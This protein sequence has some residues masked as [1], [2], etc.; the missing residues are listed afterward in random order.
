MNCGKFCSR[1]G[2][3]VGIARVVGRDA[4]AAQIDAQ[5][6]IV[7]DRVALDAIAGAAGVGRL[8]RRSRVEGNRSCPA[9]AAVPPIDCCCGAALDLDAFCCRWE[10]PSDPAKSLPMKLP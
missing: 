7:A 10:W 4:I 8:R 2:P 5:Q 9:P 6:R 1:F 3:N